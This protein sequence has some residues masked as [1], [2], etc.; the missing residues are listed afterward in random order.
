MAGAL[1]VEALRR[2]APGVLPAGAAVPHQGGVVP[3]L[4]KL[5]LLEIA[6][7]AGGDLLVLRLGRVLC[8]PDLPPIPLLFF[9]QNSR[10]VDTLLE[11]LD[12]AYPYLGTNNRLSV[13]ERAER[14]LVLEHLRR[15]AGHPARSESLFLI[16]LGIAM[17]EYVGC[18]E[19]KVEL[20]DGVVYEEGQYYAPQGD[21]FRFRVSWARQRET[22]PHIAGLD[23]FVFQVAPPVPLDDTL[24]VH[25]R[26]HLAITENPTARWTVRSASSHLGLSQRSLQRA[27][28]ADN[29]TLTLVIQQARLEIA[30]RLLLAP[31]VSVTDVAQRCGFADSA[32]LCRRF[33]EVTGQTPGEYR[34]AWLRVR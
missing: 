21:C 2:Y 5:R 32:H 13:V 22:R 15:P 3:S 8:E 11:K 28:K 25:Q 19:L 33:R 16:G 1:L 4:Y 20:A 9:I 29:T 31:D 30:R 27:L 12:R 26:L 14:S 23:D 6:Q 17:F 34:R 24:P 18:E 7:E 10:S